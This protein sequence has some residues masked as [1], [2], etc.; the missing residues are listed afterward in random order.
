MKMK[1]AVHYE[2]GKPVKVED[3]TLDEPQANEVLVKVTATGICHSDI[4]FMHGHMP[5]PLP[6][7]LGHEG[8]GVVERVG[9]GVTTLKPGDHVIM[10]VILSCGRCLH[11]I[12]GQ[13]SVCQEWL[14]YHLM[15][16]LPGGTKRLHKNGQELNHFFNQSSFAE[17]AVVTERTAIKVRDD[18]PLDVVC[19]LG[20]GTSTGI[21]AVINT[22]GFKAGQTI[23]VFGCGG[24]GL[25]A[26]MAAKLCGADKIFAVDTNDMKLQKA[27]ELGA[28][29]LINASQE[30]P[31]QR[32][33]AL[34]GRGTSYTGGGVD[35]AIEC[36]GNVTVMAQA[37][38][39]VRVAGNCVL[40]GMAPL[41]SKVSVDAWGFNVGKKII[42]SVQGDVRA[43]IDIP[44]YVDLYMAG[45]LPIDKL[46]SKR[47]KGLDNINEVIADLENG[48]VVRGVVVF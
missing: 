3:V 17:Y 25:S 8:A 22:A 35:H 9:P 13:P 29:Y 7:V 46:I 47:Y 40:A 12:E 43:Q 24:V 28:E 16:S 10:V 1:A 4:H 34:S 27:K 39:S 32:I 42:G 20:C 33:V 11:C 48:R 19:T 41:G 18:A 37:F 26:I 2:I 38:D 45:K 5:Q 31:V 6:V 44:A 23:A 36:T 21:G 30:D 15:G 14:N